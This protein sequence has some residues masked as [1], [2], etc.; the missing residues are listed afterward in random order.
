M[1]CIC[2]ILGRPTEVEEIG[3]CRDGWRLVRCRETGFVF[4]MDPPVASRL[5]QEFAWEKTYA[6]ESRRRELA[7]PVMRRVSSL[8]KRLR[9][10][11]LPRHDRMAA[12]AV[13][14]AVGI[15]HPG[16]V[17]VLDV[18]CGSG[19]RMA[20]I[21]RSLTALGR[22]VSP[23]GI[24]V[25]RHL[26]SVS[27]SL[28]SQLGGRVVQALATDAMSLFEPESIDVVVLSSFLEHEHRPLHFLR[29]ARSTLRTWGAV[30][31]KVPNYASWNR[32]V[33]GQRW[34]G[35]RIPDHVSYFTPH[36]LRLLAQEAGFRFHQRFWDRSPLSDSMYAVLTSAE[37]R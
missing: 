16:P 5:E 33:R 28:F 10:V 37:S 15:E 29:Q 4:L 17:C 27:G 23:C 22:E 13:A 7:E 31:L 11:M 1:R 6:L 35:F 25:S 14:V 34:C 21:H 30:V 3:L 26:A 20:G 12:L 2:P 8:S 9:A 36:T 18:G 19:S 24:E 32:Y